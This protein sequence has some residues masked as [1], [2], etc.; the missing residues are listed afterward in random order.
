MNDVPAPALPITR[1]TS[2]ISGAATDA[3]RRRPSRRLARASMPVTPTPVG[4]SRPTS[5]TIS[6]PKAASATAAGIATFIAM[7]WPPA[8]PPCGATMTSASAPPR[9]SSPAIHRLAVITRADSPGVPQRLQ[10]ADPSGAA[11][12]DQH[13]GDRERDAG[14]DGD[15]EDPRPPL[16]R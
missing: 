15:A 12:G 14:A 11:G 1:P 5:G 2:T 8:A 10:R 16:G 3:L 4:I 7:A 13:P 9:N 6:G